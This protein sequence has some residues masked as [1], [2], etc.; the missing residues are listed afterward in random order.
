MSKSIIKQSRMDE[1][2]TARQK[3]IITRLCIAL[4]ISEPLEENPMTIGEA[5]RLIRELQS[6]R[7]QQW[8][9]LRR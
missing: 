4:G 2:A 6:K 8:F 5:G 1:P 7:R 9:I 3:L